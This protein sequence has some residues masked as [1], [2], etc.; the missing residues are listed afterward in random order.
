MPSRYVK[1][2]ILSLLVFIGF[3]QRESGDGILAKTEANGGLFLPDGFEATVVVDSLPGRARHIAVN[4]NGDIY[5][6]ARFV[7]NKDESV[8]ALRDT[9]GDGRADIIKRF[10]GLEREH[11][12]GTAVRIYNG[13]LY[14]SSELYVYKLTPGRPRFSRRSRC[15]A[16]DFS[17]KDI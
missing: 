10:G 12:Y 13:Y 1:G 16:A 4:D 11:A 7:R 6:K 14:F 17:A 8:I 15:C 5:V 9:N 2:F 3:T